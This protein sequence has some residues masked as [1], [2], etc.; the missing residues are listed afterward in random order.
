MRRGN[1]D[2]LKSVWAEHFWQYLDEV[3][4]ARRYLKKLAAGDIE[5][6]LWLLYL[7]SSPTGSPAHQKIRKSANQIVHLLGVAAQ[8]LKEIDG[9][10]ESWPPMVE[11]GMLA[12]QH[13][14]LRPRLRR[15]VKE[16]EED[17]DQYV[18]VVYEDVNDQYL[19]MICAMI[20]DGTVKLDYANFASVLEAA[21]RASDN[22]RRFSA[23][24]VKQLVGRSPEVHKRLG[25]T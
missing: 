6:L 3:S 10:I 5:K 17:S 2:I 16:L 21:F 22:V 23:E 12:S 15:W 20:H 18:R 7:Y 9:A 8:T 4:Y 1:S 14:G 25:Y 11:V 24:D 13:S 19:I